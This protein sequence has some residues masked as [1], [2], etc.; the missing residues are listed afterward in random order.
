MLKVIITI[1]NY[2]LS[3]SSQDKKWP[4]FLSNE[5]GEGIYVSESGL[6]DILDKLFKEKF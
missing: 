6:E 3:Y 5:D 1:G 4:F 2:Y